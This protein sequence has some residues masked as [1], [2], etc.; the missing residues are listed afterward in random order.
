MAYVFLAL[1]LAF[2]I[3]APLCKWR[4]WLVALCLVASMTCL[5]LTV[6]A[7]VMMD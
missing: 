2:M 4:D 1:C 6:A 3:A 7:P 5:I